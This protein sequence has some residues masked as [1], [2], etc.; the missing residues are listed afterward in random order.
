MK[1]NPPAI[2]EHPP[3]RISAPPVHVFGT[4]SLAANATFLRGEGFASLLRRAETVEFPALAYVLEHPDG[5]VV[6][7]TGHGAHVTAPRRLRGFP[8]AP[9]PGRELG[10]QMRERGL[11]PG[12]VHTVL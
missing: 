6:I 8:P 4:G 12:D 7:D 3:T 2:R 1:I 10:L 5:L 9:V 11:D